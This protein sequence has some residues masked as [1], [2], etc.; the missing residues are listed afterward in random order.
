MVLRNNLKEIRMRI[1]MMNVTDFAKMLGVKLSTYSQWESGINSPS[2]EKAFEISKILNK[3]I[4]EI[5]H[6]E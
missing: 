4:I 6:E 2:L 5:W 3:Q 1:Y